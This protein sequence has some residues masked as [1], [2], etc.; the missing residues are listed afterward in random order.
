MPGKRPETTRDA[1]LIGNLLLR[2][3]E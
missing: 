2:K 1:K 3:Q